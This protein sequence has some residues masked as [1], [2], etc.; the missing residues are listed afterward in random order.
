MGDVSVKVISL[1][2]MLLAYLQTLC[3]PSVNVE[4]K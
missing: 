3:K 1:T 4:M 2:C